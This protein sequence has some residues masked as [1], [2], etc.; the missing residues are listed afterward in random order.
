[1][2]LLADFQNAPKTGAGNDAEY[3][4]C[5]FVCDEEG[6]YKGDNACQKKHWP[7]LSSEIVFGLDDYGM[8]YSYAEECGKTDEKTVPFHNSQFIIH[9]WASP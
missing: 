7:A 1:M 2:M 3:D 4:A 9:N 8:E 5:V 6:G